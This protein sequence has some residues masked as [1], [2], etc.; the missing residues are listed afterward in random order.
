LA[1]LDFCKNC[2]VETVAYKNKPVDLKQVLEAAVKRVGLTKSPDVVKGTKGLLNKTKTPEPLEKGL[3]RARAEVSIF[4][5]GT[6]RFDA[7]NAI[8]TQ[9]RPGEVGLS[10]EKAHTLG[11][12]NDMMGNHWNPPSSF[13]LLR[14][15]TLLSQRH[16]HNIC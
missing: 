1:G 10:V 6:I 3:L 16:A 4:K 7:T 14:S 13:A 15:R 2:N 8:L 9:F 5:D 11:Y 12:E